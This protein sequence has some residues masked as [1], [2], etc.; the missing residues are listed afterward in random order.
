LK[1]LE[2][3]NAADADLSDILR[4]GC[5]RYGDEIGFAYAASFG[6][7]FE[8]LCELPDIAPALP[9]GPPGARTWL[10]R[11]HRIVYNYDEQTLF[12]ARV[13]HA[14]MNLDRLNRG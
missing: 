4:Y 12:V 11:S 3:S 9:V 6:A 14:T 13:M 8:L 5:E 1:R 7:A 10:H 2:L